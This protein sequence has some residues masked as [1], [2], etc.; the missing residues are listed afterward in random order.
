MP[1]AIIA[2]IDIKFMLPLVKTNMHS[3]THS[4]VRH[5]ILN[6]EKCLFAISFSIKVYLIRVFK[7]LPYTTGRQLLLQLTNIR[8][9]LL[10]Q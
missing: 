8:K 3:T 10:L 5:T 7:Q 4:I 9:F 2:N 1:D 6:V